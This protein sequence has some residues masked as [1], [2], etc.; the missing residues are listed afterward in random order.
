MF[1]KHT[2]KYLLDPW[3]TSFISGESLLYEL[4]DACPLFSLIGAMD[5]SAISCSIQ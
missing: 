4:P 2:G 5:C 1:P 3:V